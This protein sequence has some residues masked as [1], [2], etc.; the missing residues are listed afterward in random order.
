MHNK[1]KQEREQYFIKSLI[2]STMQMIRQKCIWVGTLLLFLTNL[3]AFGW[4]ER[5]AQ[6]EHN[7]KARPISEKYD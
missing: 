1:Y 3:P 4:W 6:S 7:L 5:L 2:P